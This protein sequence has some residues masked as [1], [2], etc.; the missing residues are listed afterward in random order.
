MKKF[1]FRWEAEEFV[2]T[3]KDL[4]KLTRNVI[5]KDMKKSLE[6][7]LILKKMELDDKALREPR[8]PREY[9]IRNDWERVSSILKK[10]YN[11]LD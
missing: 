10:R 1:L 8:T 11:R 7:K 2:L 5:D 3:E 4:T 9:K 6:E